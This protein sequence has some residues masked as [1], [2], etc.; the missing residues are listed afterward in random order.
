MGEVN[1]ASVIQDMT[2]SY[3]RLKAFEDCR[4]RWYL[5]YIRGVRGKELFFSSYGSFLHA[6]LASHL[7]GEATADELVE[8]Y[9]LAFRQEVAARP[10]SPKIYRNYF[11]AGLSYLQGISTPPFRP[12]WVEQEVRFSA[13]GFPFVGYVDLLG[14][15]EGQLILADHKSR[16]LSPRSKRGRQTKSDRELDSYLRQ[17]Y[18]YSIPVHDAFGRFPAWLSFNCFRAGTVVEEPFRPAALEEA[19]GWAAGL[20]QTIMDESDF[21]PSMEYFKCRYLCDV[22]DSCEFFALSKGRT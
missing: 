20:I 21:P 14:D 15:K 5:K 7:R 2:W 4:Y 11:S 12:L 22:Q 13:G 3:S 16:A 10:P 1:Y 19:E 8:R 9:L 18:L 17:L 6:L